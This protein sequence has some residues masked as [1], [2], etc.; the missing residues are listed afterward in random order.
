MNNLGNR[1][2]QLTG[3]PRFVVCRVVIHLRGSEIA[4]LLGAL[5]RAAQ[6]TIEAEGDL[7]ILGGE[8]D[9]L[10]QAL[11]ELQPYW[12]SACNEG[13]VL[14]DEGEAGDY[15]NELFADSAQCYQG[16]WNGEDQIETDHPESLSLPITENLIVSLTIAAEGEVAAIETDLADVEALSDGLKALSALHYQERLRAVQVHFLPARFGDLLT[17]EQVLTNFPELV[18]L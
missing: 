4:P 15:V 5:N 14:W 17:D 1:W 3:K 18:P 2:N 10:A 16:D 6:R 12:Q 11:L 13:D 9:R 8:L 7:T